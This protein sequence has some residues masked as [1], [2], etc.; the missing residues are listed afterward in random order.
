MTTSLPTSFAPDI[1][2]SFGA[3]PVD[4]IIAELDTNEDAWSEGWALYGQGGLLGDLRKALLDATAMEV[5]EQLLKLNTTGQKI[6]DGFIEQMAH[7]NENYRQFL[8]EHVIRRAEWIRLD[9]KRKKI[10]MR[11]NRGQGLL[12]KA[13]I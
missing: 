3:V 5:R 4:E 12:R 10:E 1:E 8:D 2:R 9:S 13:S 7:A 11:Y 6:T